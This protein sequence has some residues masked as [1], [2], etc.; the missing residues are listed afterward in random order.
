MVS[1]N[2]NNIGITIQHTTKIDSS[3]GLEQKQIN[4]VV[5][6]VLVVVLL[7]L[8]LFVNQIESGVGWVFVEKSLS[9]AGGEVKLIKKVVDWASVKTTLKVWC[10]CVGLKDIIIWIGIFGP[11]NNHNMSPSSYFV[12]YWYGMMKSISTF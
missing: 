5:N 8:V 12:P 3:C 6:I 1:N 4:A 7:S 9:S 11:K 10:W 2:V